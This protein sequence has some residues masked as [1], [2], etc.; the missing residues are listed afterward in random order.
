MDKLLP[1]RRNYREI[2][3]DWTEG[4]LDEKQNYILE[5]REL[6]ADVTEIL[7]G[8]ASLLVGEIRDLRGHIQQAIVP[9][10]HKRSM[11]HWL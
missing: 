10:Q 5:L 2:E 7:G 3:V 11:D 4:S 9:A 8:P 1:F 6:E